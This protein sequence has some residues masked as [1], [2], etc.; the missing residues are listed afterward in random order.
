VTQS[1]IPFLTT[2][3][4]ESRRLDPLRELAILTSYNKNDKLDVPVFLPESK[5]KRLP[6]RERVVKGFSL[7][8]NKNSEAGRSLEVPARALDLAVGCDVRY[9]PVNDA[10]I[11][12]SYPSPRALF[13]IDV[14]LVFA[15]D[16]EEVKLVYDKAHHAVLDN[17]ELKSGQTSA[18]RDLRIRLVGSMEKIAPLYGDLAISLCALEVGHLAHQICAA[19]H[20]LGVPFECR[21]LAAPHAEEHQSDAEH[22]VPLVDI[23]FGDQDYVLPAKEEFTESLRIT[24]HALSNANWRAVTRELRWIASPSSAVRIIHHV[25]RNC[26]FPI[27][28]TAESCHRSAGNIATGTYGRSATSD[29]LD[30]FVHSIL[31]EYRASSKGLYPRPALTI[32]RSDPSFDVTVIHGEE[33]L[34]QQVVVN[35]CAPLS[36]AYGTF[37]NIDMQTIPLVVGF[38]MDVGLL[39]KEQS[40]WSYLE[41]LVLAGTYSQRICNE[42]ASRGFSARPFKGARED[43]LETAFNLSGQCFYTILLGKSAERNPALS[44]SSLRSM[45]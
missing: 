41:M 33:H 5:G 24:E 12:L 38:T 28:P 19:L 16:G 17:P 45:E 1:S 13:P 32:L 21:M 25:G 30:A 26:T 15:K 36:E 3:H 9:E 29:E 6:L 2:F 4:E 23:A 22:I 10:P 7:Y 40:S 39:V 27:K 18:G 35:G 42:A 44:L 20:F 37:Y 34:P 43:V 14:Y 8:K 31:N 11:H